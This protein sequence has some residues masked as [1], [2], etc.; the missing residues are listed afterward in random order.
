VN[1]GAE[2][3]PGPSTCSLGARFLGREITDNL[4]GL[5]GWLAEALPSTSDRNTVKSRVANFVTGV[6]RGRLRLPEHFAPEVRALANLTKSELRR[7]V[8]Y[9]KPQNADGLRLP[10][11][12]STYIR[13]VMPGGCVRSVH[14]C[15]TVHEW[16]RKAVRPL[17]ESGWPR[18]GTKPA[19]PSTPTITELLEMSRRGL[20]PLPIRKHRHTML[21]RVSMA[22]FRADPELCRSV[23]SDNVIG[24]RSDIR[25]PSKYL[26]YLSYRWGFLILDIRQRELPTG[27]ARFVAGQW[28]RNPGNLWLQDKCSLKTFLRET[29]RTRLTSTN[30][31]IGPW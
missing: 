12:L 14:G 5:A 22:Q 6:R 15:P 21:H 28:I 16:Q 26:D 25:V 27:L 19:W 20:T 31:M 7:C 9:V 13:Q 1:C 11:S 2:K 29:P 4:F 17:P 18:L 10:K 24:I 23:V 3:R 30:G 8:Y